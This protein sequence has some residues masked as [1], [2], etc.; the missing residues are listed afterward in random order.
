[1]RMASDYRK[2]QTGGLWRS[3][4]D[5]SDGNDESGRRE[6]VRERE[7]EMRVVSNKR[8]GPVA[9]SAQRSPPAPRPARSVRHAPKTKERRT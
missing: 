2:R 6:T 7:R 8:C 1:M 3:R 9:F 4:L 5:E